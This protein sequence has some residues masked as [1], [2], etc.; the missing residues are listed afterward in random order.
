MPL[1]HQSHHVRCVETTQDIIR[2][3]HAVLTI[4]HVL[5]ECNEMVK[6]IGFLF[7]I[8]VWKTRGKVRDKVMQEDP[9]WS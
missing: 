5:H 6:I 4:R 9:P 3:A 7:V 1:P 8:H 2:E